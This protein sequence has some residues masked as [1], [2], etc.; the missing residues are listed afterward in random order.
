MVESFSFVISHDGVEMMSKLNVRQVGWICEHLEL[1]ARLYECSNRENKGM[2]ARAFRRV[3]PSISHDAPYRM[4][5][6]ELRSIKFVGPAIVAKLKEL[7]EN[8]YNHLT[9][10]VKKMMGEIQG[11]GIYV[12]SWLI[13]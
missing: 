8:N 2:K 5:L 9:P 13:E 6:D 3:I 10:T 1:I 12:R 11:S 7:D 4:D